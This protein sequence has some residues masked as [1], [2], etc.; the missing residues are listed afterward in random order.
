MKL[1]LTTKIFLG[2]AAL[3]STFALLAFASIKEFQAVGEDLRSIN[4]G[5][6]VLARLAGQLE[7]LQQNRF[8]DLGR[9]QLENDPRNR[10][11]ILRIATAYFPDVV[12]ARLDEVRALCERQEARLT[13]SREDRAR[14]REFFRSIRARMDQIEE[15]HAA[16]DE[17]SEHLFRLAR[18][19]SS[20][21][22]LQPDIE[23]LDQLLSV[24]LYALN[25]TIDQETKRAVA[26]AERDERN[27]IWRVIGM[28][29]G[30]I[31]VG[32]LLTYLSARA[33]TP[34][35]ELVAYARAI[36]RGDYDREVG[37][38]GGDELSQLS[39]ELQ[40]MA[41]SRK[42]RETE[43]D[44][45][46]AELEQAYHRVGELKRYHES[47]V[48]SLKTAVLVT[49][50][51]L[52]V[53]S[54]NR[55]AESRFAM[56]LAD[57]RG[58]KL[59]ELP[60]GAAMIE[61]TGALELLVESAA[62][63]YLTAV[64]LGDLRVDVSVTPFQNELGDVLGLVLALEDVTEAVHTKEALIRSER[65]AA[66]GRMSAHVTHE[67]R[68][69]LSSIGL[70]AELLEALIGESGAPP[71]VTS[72]AQAL[73]RAIGREVDRLTAITED[74]LRFARLP[75]PELSAEDLRP[76][77]ASVAA[78]VRR[79]CEAAGVKLVLH[80]PDDA[81]EAEIDADQMRQALLNLVRNAKES[82][83][84]G[85]VID[86]GIEAEGSEVAM[87]VRDSGVGID[88]D[89]IDRIFDPFYSTKLTGTGLGLAL[90]HQIVAEHGGSL[91]VRSEVGSG[92]EFRVVVRAAGSGRV[93]SQPPHDSPES[94]APE[95]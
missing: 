29:L 44:R 59:H 32:L 33:L 56:A 45:Q 80:L 61:R 58:K 93:R 15:G 64:P 30:A 24:E 6:L 31:L 49:D 25:N 69:P 95:S 90:C 55:A 38:K 9:A 13:G 19:G 75:R 73:S 51:E 3:L 92:S 48:Q 76:L 53:T 84:G 41:R 62:P 7:T 63:V 88:P 23:R 89:N 70:N 4:E 82:M 54:A 17:L 21:A 91:R 27:A 40:Q 85:G 42:E 71:A 87:F 46:Q 50:R 67:V 22:G 36:S 34:I 72:E 52:A 1:S 83:P 66:I 10:E 14:K 94:R 74:Y 60:V 86:L 12:R 26:R 20:P 65:L 79:D 37:I 8:R 78:F 5:H 47:V 2:F 57:V 81:P 43:L 39:E 18:L 28:T 68:N 11:V 35:R 16:L 77:L